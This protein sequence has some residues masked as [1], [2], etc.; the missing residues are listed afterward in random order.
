MRFTSS[1][2]VPA[3]PNAYSYP[4]TELN[5]F[6]RYTRFTFQQE[7]GY[8]A[9]TYDPFRR[10]KRWAD[11]SALIDE[12]GNTYPDPANELI[13]YNTFDLMSGTFKKMVMTRLEASQFNLP[14]KVVYSKYVNTSTTTAVIISPDGSTTPLNGSLFV[15]TEDAFAVA[16]E[17]M[18]DVPNSL[19]T[20]AETPTSQNDPFRVVYG[21]E[22]RRQM[23]FTL[24]FPNIGYPISM[25]AASLLQKRFDAGYWAP[26]KWVVSNTGNPTFVPDTIPDG[27]QDTR[28]EVPFP[29][30]SLRSNEVAKPTMVGIWQIIR[31]DVADPGAPV[32][33]VGTGSGCV[34]AGADSKAYAMLAAIYNKVVD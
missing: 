21:A 4:A 6:K 12:T 31:T 25:D 5:L 15:N 27:E 14:G 33:L 16:K 34:F 3:Q 2:K 28:P 17:L 8:E 24:V 19:V 30:R 10:I 18:N 22:T 1:P 13:Q 32:T 29:V 23:T 11:T 9:E 20:V 26:G 7:T